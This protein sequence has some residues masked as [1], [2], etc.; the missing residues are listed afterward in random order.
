VRKL[1]IVVAVTVAGLTVGCGS[2]ARE[3][4]APAKGVVP[5]AD[6]PTAPY[7]EPGPRKFATDARPCQSSDLRMS[8]GRSGVGLGHTNVAIQFTNRSATACVLLGYPKVAGIPASGP[9]TPLAATHGSYFGDPGPPANIAPGQT[10]AVNVSGADACHAAQE[11]QHRFYRRLRIGLPGGGSMD[12]PAAPFDAICGVSVSQF[13]VPA[14]QPAVPPPSPLTARITAAAAVRPGED[15][16]YTVTLTNP[17]ATAYPLRPCPAYEEYVYAI[18]GPGKAAARD[19]HVVKNYYLKCDTVHEISA[20]HSVT[21]Q[22]R[23][24]LPPGLPTG[25]PAKFVW[26]LQGLAGPGTSA[27]LRIGT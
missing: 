1:A 7:A 3:A 19:D 13:G 23:L 14:G 10:A 22:M 21:Y 17:T 16:T 27:P 24:Q 6:R 8:P 12:A 11:G 2:P 18:T 9:S 20:H 25:V 4:G 26:L 15:F 5:W